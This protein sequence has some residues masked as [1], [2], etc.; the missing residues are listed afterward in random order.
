MNALQF[1]KLVVV[2]LARR[3][4]RQRD[5][6]RLLHT[7]DTTLSDWLRGAHPAPPDL[8]TRIERAFKLPAGTLGTEEQP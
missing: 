3:D 1:R 8:S 4:L 5:L 6:A 2:E 7:P